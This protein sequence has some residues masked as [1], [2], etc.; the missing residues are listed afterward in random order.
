MSEDNEGEKQS[1]SG[2]QHIPLHYRTHLDVLP[3]HTPVLHHKGN[4]L[5]ALADTDVQQLGLWQR[6]EQAMKT[7]EEALHRLLQSAKLAIVR[8][9][10]ELAIAEL[11]AGDMVLQNNGDVLECCNDELIEDGSIVDN[12]R[13]RRLL[14]ILISHMSSRSEGEQKPSESFQ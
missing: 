1:A 10:L 6:L 7:G 5:G 9:Q 8:R 4:H 14:G 12:V 3:G 2:L 11:L 13:Q